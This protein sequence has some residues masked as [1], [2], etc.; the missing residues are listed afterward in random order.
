MWTTWEDGIWKGQ[1]I[2]DY[3]IKWPI[4]V[5]CLW[6]IIKLSVLYL[7]N[8]LYLYIKVEF[9]KWENTTVY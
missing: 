6:S 1:D 8:I 4:Y 9:Y 3:V 5:L 7:D 2:L